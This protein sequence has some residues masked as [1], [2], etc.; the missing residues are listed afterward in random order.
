[1]FSR[2]KNP[3][4]FIGIMGVVTAVLVSSW[5]TRP[6]QAA[7]GFVGASSSTLSIQGTSITVAAPTGVQSGHYM[8]ASVSI[9]NT[10]SS[11]MPDDDWTNIQD[12]TT[13]LSNGDVVF[14]TFGKFFSPGETS[15]TFSWTGS[16][17]ASASI[18]AY[19]GVDTTSPVMASA[20][21]INPSA[22][23]TYTAPSVTTTAANALVVATYGVSGYTDMT[24]GSGM[25]R[26]VYE[27]S[28]VP[29]AAQDVVQST[30]GA[31]GTKTMT[32]SSYKSVGVT[33][34]LTPGTPPA[35]SQ[36]AYRW[37][38]NQD[39]TT[40]STY[41]KSF[42]STGFTNVERY[43]VRPT[44]DGG[45]VTAGDILVSTQ[46][47][48]YISKHA[49]NGTVTWMRRWTYGASNTTFNDVTAT[50]DGGYVAVGTTNAQLLLIKYD[51]SGA[52]SWSR[53]WKNN[54][55][56][57]EADGFSVA[58]L[59]DGSIVVGGSST[60]DSYSYA[61]VV[62][63]NASGT[64]QWSREWPGSTA[65]SAVDSASD[66]GFYIGGFASF[67]GYVVKYTS[68]GAQ[69]WAYT[70]SPMGEVRD[71]HETSDGGFLVQGEGIVAK[72]GSSWTSVWRT[73][74]NTMAASGRGVMTSDGGYV[75]AGSGYP[76]EQIIA[77]LNSS[78][79]LVWDTQYTSPNPML[80]YGGVSQLTDGT[81]VVATD[82]GSATKLEVSRYTST[83]QIYNCS[84]CADGGV[85]TTSG[86]STA[87]LSSTASTTPGNTTASITGTH[88]T[89]TL[90]PT[91]IV[92]EAAVVDV[93][94]PL[95]GA[96]QN[97][98]T[99]AP[100]SGVPFRL[101][102]AQHVTNS[103]LS[104]ASLKLQF[105]TRGADG[106]CDTS[107]NGE[108]YADVT[109]TSGIAYYN[110]T[111]AVDGT[112]AT[113]NANDPV[114]AGHTNIMQEYNE[115]NPTAVV[116]AV[117]TGSDGL[118]DFA[119]KD[120]N[121]TSG[122][123]CFRM[124]YNTGTPLEAYSV[125]PELTVPARVLS[126]DFVDGT[127]TVLANPTYD[128]VGSVVDTSVYQSTSS[129]FGTA[130]K[131]IRVYNGLAINGWNLTLSP[132][133]G[134]TALWNKSDSSAK[135]DFNDSGANATDSGIDTDGY[136]GQLSSNPTT[137]AIASSC[138]LTGVALGSSG[139]FVEGTVNS[140]T[141]INATSA[142]AMYCNW[143]LTGVTLT[144][145]I[146][147]AQPSGTYTIGMTVT[148]TQL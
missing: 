140:V 79:V 54:T 23:T 129:T 121:A 61:A 18:V 36:T 89:I 7:I 71:I 16:V 103:T 123:Y 133:D 55:S 131:K 74:L 3:W 148:A 42:A 38:E 49:A 67:D 68:A 20:V 32:G 142:A 105:A 102:V 111:A 86:T 47:R 124:V 97:S 98:A 81:L 33:I 35:L 65:V 37:F 96:A 9:K 143:D 82:S 104:S 135:Y 27:A 41:I 83:G 58:E 144:Q 136:G 46:K 127:N 4:Q 85:T 78:G 99:N 2:V 25:T 84:I 19:S 14:H 59:T 116:G 22:S 70:L 66:G 125:I 134:A 12:D 110:N 52:L 43:A 95:G 87:T 53:V 50:S 21:Q 138:P 145:T 141:L 6:A 90:T 120:N 147:K 5:I 108:T 113:A 139:N 106:L 48:G 30:A 63:Y 109:T 24:A 112:I 51:S 91:T 29:T 44:S 93:G 31:S 28:G 132:T 137:G 76:N 60:H 1:M 13:G 8:I 122:T 15:Y 146:P 88:A 56:G 128:F 130:T 45:Y 117:A 34:A 114:H 118:W 115:T 100:A 101:R 69:Q 107:F 64:F 39:A 10:T 94:A 57:A 75:V 126:V 72:Y 62:K 17:Y 77:K 92:G 40:S 26:R 119:L 11:F 73:D 80:G